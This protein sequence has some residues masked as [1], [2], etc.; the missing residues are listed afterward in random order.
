MYEY[1]TKTEKKGLKPITI[2][3]LKKI[4][5]N[6]GVEKGDVLMVHSSISSLGY[7]VGGSEAIYEALI[8]IIGPEGTIVV[9]SQTVDISDPASWQY[10]PVPSD[11][12]EIIRLVCI[13]L[14]LKC[15]I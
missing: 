10:P 4:F 5:L 6:V 1:L 3:D 14:C 12:F 15:M 13:L 11:W 7:V 2:C 8:S 9:P